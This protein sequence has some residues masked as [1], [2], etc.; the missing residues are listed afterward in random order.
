MAEELATA[1]L[2]FSPTRKRKHESSWTCK[3]CSYVN[4]EDPDTCAGCLTDNPVDDSHIG[5]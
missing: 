1:Q 3:E 4:T 2:L 5:M